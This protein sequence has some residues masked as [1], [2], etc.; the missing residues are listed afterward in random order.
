MIGGTT[1]A[2]FSNLIGRTPIPQQDATPFDYNNP[3][4]YGGYRTR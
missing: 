2:Y 4:F 1:P 3:W